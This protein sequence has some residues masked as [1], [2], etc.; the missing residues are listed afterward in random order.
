MKSQTDLFWDKQ[1]VSVADETAVNIHDPEQR[2][3]EF[4]FLLQQLRPGE[5]V[6]EVGCGNG[7]STSRF[8]PHTGHVDAFDYSE[9]MV[10]RA[11]ST[12]GESNNRFFH[13]NVLAPQ[14]LAPDGYD[15]VICVRVL[16]NLRDLHEQKRALANIADAVKT[17]GRL[18]LLEG[19]RDGFEALNRVRAGTGLPPLTPAPINFYS[20]IS[21]LLDDLPPGLDI[22]LQVFDTGWYDYLTRI[23]YPV[24]I[25]PEK[26]SVGTPEAKRLGSL[27]R[28]HRPAG[29]AEFG[30]VRGLLLK[31][32]IGG[33][34]N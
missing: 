21:E 6:L 20:S 1:A 31:K 15:L 16:I 18:L 28:A 10:R 24:L 34:K 19:F 22:P 27:A 14:L 32:V 2:E 3:I 8:R 29:F 13:D 5:R 11:K 33:S 9:A 7:Y 23:V 17:G 12:F 25:E 26:I 4:D 30:R